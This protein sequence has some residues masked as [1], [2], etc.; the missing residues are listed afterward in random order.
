[1][2]ICWLI[3]TFHLK[4]YFE[5]ADRTGG[6]MEEY[7]ILIGLEKGRRA[8]VRINDLLG[9][10]KTIFQTP[11]EVSRT[12]QF[13]TLLSP[14]TTW[15]DFSQHLTPLELGLSSPSSFFLAQFSRYEGRKGIFSV[16]RDE[17]KTLEVWVSHTKCMERSENSK[18]WHRKE[19]EAGK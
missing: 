14:I 3:E 13:V 5:R 11:L 8:Q 10:R 12:Y 19:N 4:S 6:R 18:K 2:F 17:I 1:M 16:Q 9:D 15:V 7:S